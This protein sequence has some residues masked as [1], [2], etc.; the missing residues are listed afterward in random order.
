ML[1]NIKPIS[2]IPHSSN[3]ST[4]QSSVNTGVANTMPITTRVVG[5]I[6]NSNRQENNL[7]H[8]FRKQVFSPYLAPSNGS[9]TESFLNQIKSKK[10]WATT[11]A[12][13]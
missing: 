4:A 13:K 8:N 7:H 6:K 2:T 1:P 9:T 3:H 10:S 5:D 12:K 11:T